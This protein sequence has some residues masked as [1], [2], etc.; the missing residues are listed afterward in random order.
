MP[1]ICF[2]GQYGAEGVGDV[3]DGHQLGTRRQHPLVFVHHQLAGL[4]DGHD[5]EDDALFLAEHLPGNDVGVMLHVGNDDL[6]AGAE[7]LF[8]ERL[9]YGVDAVGGAAGEHDFVVIGG[10]EQALD[11]GA[12]TLV[13]VS[14]VLAEGMHAPVNVG[15]LGGV[16]AHQL[17]YDRLRLLRR[18]AVVEVDQRPAVDLLL[19][20]RKIGPDFFRIE[21][22]GH[23]HS[24]LIRHSRKSGNLRGFRICQPILSAGVWIPAFAGMTMAVGYTSLFSRE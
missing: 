9:G 5:S 17:V 14:G 10:V 21:T 7:V 8:A 2:D 23:L 13:V 15:V 3:R 22:G 1:I 16:V 4:V 18:C 6:I 20:D 11:L 19:Q 24:P 12:G